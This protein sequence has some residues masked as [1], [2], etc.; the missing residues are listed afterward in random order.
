MVKKRVKAKSKPKKV[1]SLLGMDLKYCVEYDYDTDRNCHEHGCDS[2]CRCGTISDCRVRIV[3][4]RSIA[5]EIYGKGLSD[6]EKYC[7]ERIL[8]AHKVYQTSHYEIPIVSG[9]Y[10]QE[11]GNITL[12]GYIAR[13]CDADIEKM[14]SKRGD[15]RKIEFVLEIEYGYV[16]SILKGRK[17]EIVKVAKND[18][19]FGQEDHY[20]RLDKD[21]VKMYELDDERGRD[22]LPRGVCIRDGSRYRVID[23][24]HRCAAAKRTCK[25]YVAT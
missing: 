8:V 9:Y 12:D 1:K 14:L 2:I 5:Q 21:V 13:A 19:V 23:G 24:Y 3:D 11:V 4:I 25:V 16:L 10:G 17:F 22:G 7:I 20:R 6:T 18:L 15:S